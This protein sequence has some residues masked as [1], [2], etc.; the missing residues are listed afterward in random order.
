MP[1]KPHITE[2]TPVTDEVLNLIAHLPTG[3]LPAIVAD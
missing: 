3:S 2:A 1:T